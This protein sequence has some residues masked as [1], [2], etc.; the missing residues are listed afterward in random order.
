VVREVAASDMKNGWYDY[1]EMVSRN[2]EEIVLTRYGKP[3]AMLVPY[4]EEC[5]PHSLYGSMK[6]SMTIH[7]DIVSPLELDWEADDEEGI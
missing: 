7:G 5:Q 6:G 2:R 4:T 1:L 3:I